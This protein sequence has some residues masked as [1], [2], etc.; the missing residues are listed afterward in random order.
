MA[1]RD[2]LREVI[3]IN[4]SPKKIAISFAVG[5]FIGMSPILGLHTVL[6]IAA[7]WIF[8]LNKFV[9]IIGVYIT[10]PWTIVPIYTFATWVGAKILGISR[11]MPNINWN[12]IS[13]TYLLKEMKPLLL[14][15]VFG[16][17]LLGFFSAV[18]GYIIIY[19]AARSRK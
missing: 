3:S 5:I 12:D 19:H 11:I 13:L 4:D 10:N 6:G 18:A 8:R 2:K 14:P 15:F 1:L 9:T 17:T 7:A 16:T